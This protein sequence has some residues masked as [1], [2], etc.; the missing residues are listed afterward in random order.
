MHILTNKTKSMN[1]FLITLVWALFIGFNCFAQAPIPF[2]SQSNDRYRIFHPLAFWDTGDERMAFKDS[3]LLIVGCIY[4]KSNIWPCYWENDKKVMLGDEP[5]LVS[6][7]FVEGDDVY[8]SGFIFQDYHSP[9]PCYWKN[10]KQYYL[11]GSGW[12]SSLVFS[13]SDF[14][15]V[16]VLLDGYE[17]YPCYWKNGKLEKLSEK[18]GSINSVFASKNGDIYYAGTS[19]TKAAYW[20]NDEMVKLSKSTGIAQSIYVSDNDVYVVGIAGSSNPAKCWKNNKKHKL[21]PKAKHAAVIREFSGNLYIGGS[22]KGFGLNSCSWKNG[23]LSKI[24]DTKGSVISIEE[25]NSDI[26]FLSVTILN[27]RME[28]SYWK[29]GEKVVLEN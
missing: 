12:A 15:V 3:T 10:G 5:G 2:E 14:Y 11:P 17:S 7:I 6:G 1:R 8:M 13:N 22:R 26:Y 21:M 9:K 27:N 4:D 16:G 18:Q 28:Y 29:N 19:G 25:Y 23:E 20:K 24:N